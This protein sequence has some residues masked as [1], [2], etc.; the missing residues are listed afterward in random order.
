MDPEVGS[1]DCWTAGNLAEGDD[2][3]SLVELCEPGLDCVLEPGSDPFE[4][5]CRAYCDTDDACPQGRSCQWTEAMGAL[6]VCL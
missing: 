5:Y 1:T 6:R 3:S 2:C 4:Y